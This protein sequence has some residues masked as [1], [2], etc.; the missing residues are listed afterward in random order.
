MSIEEM[1]NHWNANRTNS[2]P[3]NSNKTSKTRSIINWIRIYFYSI[4]TFLAINQVLQRTKILLDDHR[5]TIT[6]RI[7][8]TDLSA[9]RGISSIESWSSISHIR[10][11]IDFSSQSRREY[12]LFRSS[13]DLPTWS[14]QI[15]SPSHQRYLQI[16]GYWFHHSEINTFSFC[17][18]DS[19]IDFLPTDYQQSIEYMV[20]SSDSEYL[21]WINMEIS[22]TEL[23]ISSIDSTISPNNSMSISFN[24]RCCQCAEDWET[25]VSDWSPCWTN[26][27]ILSR[28][29]YRINSIHINYCVA[30]D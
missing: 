4:H 21:R 16:Y 6:R 19:Y 3:S 24:D 22:S 5:F 20:D 18:F 29:W 14:F 11:S 10:W 27:N 30:E 13:I 9:I 26:W 17:L 2:I 8:R 25:C 7:L 12:H 28:E 15:L 1:F 23:F